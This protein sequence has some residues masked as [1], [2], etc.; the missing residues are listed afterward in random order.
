[1]QMVIYTRL[2]QPIRVLSECDYITVYLIV[3]PYLRQ[4]PFFVFIFLSS[5]MT[6]VCIYF[7]MTEL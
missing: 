2:I 5:V 6:L 4:L 7:I 1:M 3:S